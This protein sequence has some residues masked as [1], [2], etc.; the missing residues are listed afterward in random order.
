MIRVPLKE[1]KSTN[2]FSAFILTLFFF[3]IKYLIKNLHQIK[4]I[5]LLFENNI[6]LFF[7]QNELV[8]TLNNKKQS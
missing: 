5:A 8:I 2:L 1:S 6:L 3:P 4:G 7:N